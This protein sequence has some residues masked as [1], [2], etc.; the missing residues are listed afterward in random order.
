MAIEPGATTSAIIT[1]FLPFP[2]ASRSI[3][4]EIQAPFES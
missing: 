2:K 3:N 4:S 1:H